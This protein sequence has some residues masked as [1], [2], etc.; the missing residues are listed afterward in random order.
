VETSALFTAQSLGFVRLRYSGTSRTQVFGWNKHTFGTSLES[1]GIPWLKCDTFRGDAVSGGATL[2]LGSDVKSRFTAGKQYYVDVISGVD[3]GHRFEIDEAA[4]TAAALT[5]LPTNVWSTKASVSDLTGM[6][7][8]V[9]EHRTLDEVFDKTKFHPTFSASTADRVLVFGTTPDNANRRY[10]TYWLAGSG[11]SR[12]WVREDDATLSDQGSRVL[13]S[14]E[15]YLVHSRGGATAI[16][17]CGMVRDS[18]F[19]QPVAGGANLFANGYPMAM[20]F[21][22]SAFMAASGFTFTFSPSTADRISF[23][24]GDTNAGAASYTNYVYLGA[25]AAGATWVGE[26]DGSLANQNAALLM[27]PQRAFI[28]NA[29]GSRSNHVETRPWNP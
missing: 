25:N 4:S 20:S 1:Y 8:A 15:G 12:Q 22:N 7:V 3:A 5:L 2:N 17:V 24:N 18:A 27:K 13:P 28:M 14:G 23:W 21:T 6:T 11:A 19:A 29:R 9:R 26:N 16:T 10:V